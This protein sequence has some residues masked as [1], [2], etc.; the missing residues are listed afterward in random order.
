MAKIFRAGARPAATF[1]VEI[2]GLT[3]RGLHKLRTDSDKFRKP[4]HGGVSAS[5]KVVLLG[6]PTV[7]IAMAPVLQWSRM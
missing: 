2:T 1:G 6:D 5:A 7:A 3:D 4:C